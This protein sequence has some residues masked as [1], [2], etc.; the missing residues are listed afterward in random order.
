MSAFLCTPEHIQAII[1]HALANGM[2]DADPY[3]VAVAFAK[4]NI[5]S[6]E[7]RYPDTKG[8][9][10][11]E[12]FS[13]GMFRSNKAYIDACAA[14]WH[15]DMPRRRAESK[16]K[17]GEVIKLIDCLEYQSCETPNWTRTVAFEWWN[18]IARQ[19]ARKIK[20]YEKAPWTI[21]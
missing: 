2:L 1:N 10:A 7:Y 3:T 11:K 14:P 5:R 8:H 15:P 4:Q 6:V 16:L 19:A 13:D 21:D 20:G 12:F 18:S 9:S 17:A